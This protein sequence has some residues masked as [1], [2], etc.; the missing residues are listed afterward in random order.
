MKRKEPDSTSIGR[1]LTLLYEDQKISIVLAPGT[2]IQHFKKDIATKFS[3]KPENLV[4]ILLGNGTP[5]SF[6][7][8]CRNPSS[9]ADG[10]LTLIFKEDVSVIKSGTFV[11]GRCSQPYEESTNT[12]RSCHWHKGKLKVIRSEKRARTQTHGIEIASKNDEDTETIETPTDNNEHSYN[13]MIYRW[14]CCGGRRKSPGCTLGLKHTA[15]INEGL[16]RAEKLKRLFTKPP[17]DDDVQIIERDLTPINIPGVNTGGHTNLAQFIDENKSYCLNEHKIQNLNNL[18]H[19]GPGGLE[20]DCDP[21]LLIN[22]CFL[23]ALKIHSL[24]IT[25]PNDGRA[26]KTIKLFV[27]R[28]DMDFSDTQKIT[29]TQVLTLKDPDDFQ[30]NSLIRVNFVKFQKCTALTI[31]VIANSSDGSQDTTVFDSLQIIGSACRKR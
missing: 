26:P 31:F 21:Q 7:D 4:S 28:L 11:C 19:G 8:V 29:E 16:N 24:R 18:L 25:A 10:E 27:D 6:G 13:K 30:P 3:Q 14:T 12:N 20:S 5:I 22:F 1:E 2:P 15:L 17:E 9:V 23:E